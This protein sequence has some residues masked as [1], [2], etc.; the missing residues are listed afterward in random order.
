[1]APELPGKLAGDDLARAKA[2]QE[3]GAALS[4][5]V[6]VEGSLVS[7]GQTVG[8]HRAREF[9]GIATLE[10]HRRKGHAADVLADLL[11]QNKQKG[12][13]VAWLTPGDPNAL[14]LYEKVGF[15]AVADYVAYLKPT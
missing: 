4:S 3:S 12:A 2:D 5:I 10:T 8:D 15:R 14:A 7:F 9:V 11:H 1:M 13:G 6:V